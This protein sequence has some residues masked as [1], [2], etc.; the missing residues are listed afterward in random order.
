MGEVRVSEL[1]DRSLEIIKVEKQKNLKKN[2]QSPRNLW[3][4][5]KWSHTHITKVPKGEHR[6]NEAKYI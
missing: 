3:E 5:I 6:E 1:E 4:N 2:E